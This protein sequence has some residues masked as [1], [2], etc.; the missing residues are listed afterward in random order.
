MGP[1]FQSQLCH[2]EPGDFGQSTAS[3]NLLA[4]LYSVLKGLPCSSG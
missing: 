2:V 4:Y 3:L 1:R